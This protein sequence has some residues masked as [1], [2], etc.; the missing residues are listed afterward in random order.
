MPET[1]PENHIVEYVIILAR[2]L[3]CSC[4]V[5]VSDVLRERM[6]VCIYVCV[7][8]CVYVIYTALQQAEIE[9]MTLLL[10]IFCRALET[11]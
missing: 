4:I 6:P 3:D 7:T 8:M 1:S 5:K 11:L 9:S 2:A 10:M